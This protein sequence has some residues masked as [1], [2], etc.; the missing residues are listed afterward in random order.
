MLIAG[1]LMIILI[2]L[3]AASVR[4]V[5]DGTVGLVEQLGQVV[6]G[7]RQPGLLLLRPF[8]ETLILLPKG[9]FHVEL[10]LEAETWERVPLTFAVEM[11]CEVKDPV[12]LD[13]SLPGVPRG[14]LRER[15]VRH[16]I[17][18]V[19]RFLDHTLVSEGR[20]A[21]RKGRLIECLGNMDDLEKRIQERLGW[22]G[23]KQGLEILSLQM[24]LLEIPEDARQQ[25]RQAIQE[26]RAGEEAELVLEDVDPPAET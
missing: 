18:R 16:T 13:Q 26:G 14:E 24:S 11:E 22:H 15:G 5:P 17:Q 21:V 19:S 20:A 4:V 1:L 7:L 9:P 8:F 6:P 2:P 25:L 3:I 23:R 10:K 12:L